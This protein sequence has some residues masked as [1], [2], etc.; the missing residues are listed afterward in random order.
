MFS[1]IKNL[2]LQ[3]VVDLVVVDDDLVMVDDDLVVVD[4]VDLVEVVVID[5]NIREY[6][7]LFKFII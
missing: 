6:S 3:V 1:P 5:L 4:E 7:L 2:N